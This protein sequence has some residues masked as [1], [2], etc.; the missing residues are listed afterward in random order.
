MGSL[1]QISAEEWGHDLSAPPPSLIQM[2]MAD[3]ASDWHHQ[4]VADQCF[5]RL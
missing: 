2:G 4:S 3:E 1:G 5:L